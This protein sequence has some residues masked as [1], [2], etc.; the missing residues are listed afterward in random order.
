MGMVGSLSVLGSKLL[1]LL[2]QA[3]LIEKNN[4]SV[5]NNLGKAETL[6]PIDC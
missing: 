6:S 3:D 1:I 5:F 4:S 2:G